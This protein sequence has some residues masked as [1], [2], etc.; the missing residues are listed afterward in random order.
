MWNTETFSFILF[1][2]WEVCRKHILQTA[3]QDLWIH[4]PRTPFH[5]FPALLILNTRLFLSLTHHRTWHVSVLLRRLFLLPRIV[6]LSQLQNH[7]KTKSPLLWELFSLHFFSRQNQPLSQSTEDFW[8]QLKHSVFPEHLERR[9]NRPWDERRIC[10]PSWME[11]VK[12]RG[13]GSF[14]VDPEPSAKLSK[15]QMLVNIC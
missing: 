11:L 7:F 9:T 15:E 1:V 13:C 10:H 6:P 5:L 3:H 12:S 8:S 2:N 14:F 4:T